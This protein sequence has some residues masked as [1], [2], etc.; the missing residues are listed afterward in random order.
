MSAA[1]YRVLFLVD[2][3][4]VLSETFV[5]AQITGLIRR[6]CEV[7]V[8]ALW[9]GARSPIHRDVITHALLDRTRYAFRDAT[10]PVRI[11]YSAGL[12]L[13]HVQR[14]RLWR[15][16]DGF[17]FGRDAWSLRLCG[18]VGLSPERPL[19]YDAVV[20]HFGPLGLLARNLRTIG[21]LQ[22]PIITFF[23]A[24]DISELPRRRGHG[25][26]APLFRDGEL[27]CAISE[28]GCE[29]LLALGCPPAKLRLHRM[30]VVPEMS[31]HSASPQT[32]EKGKPMRVLTVARLTEKKGVAYA[33]QA[34]A[35]CRGR[36]RLRYTVVGDGPERPRLAFLCEAL[37][38]ETLVRFEGAVDHEAVAR[39]LREADVFLLPSVTARG[40]DEEGIPVALME[41]MARGLPVISTRHAGIAE[42]V[43][44]GISGF[45]TNERDVVAL[46]QALDHMLESP[47]QRR[48]LGDAGRRRILAEFHLEVL[49]DRLLALVGEVAEAYRRV[50]R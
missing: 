30:G 25:M 3:F 23:H 14:R 8:V 46:A 18:L 22:G 13:R 35:L 48:A 45:L 32:D 1:R 17:S 19:H 50:S 16:L 5:L 41:A 24:N 6:A 44:D 39:Y 11:L 27:M 2:R 43:E 28:H 26:Y 33:L 21:V 38:L 47:G 31:P 49:N 9:P 42:L 10:W 15:S 40:G 29:R 36:E 12:V 4:P 34:L 20:C 7:D 37:G